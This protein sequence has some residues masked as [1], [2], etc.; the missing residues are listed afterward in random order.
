MIW[1][2]V[3]PSLQSESAFNYSKNVLH[4][5]ANF[6]VDGVEVECREVIYKHLVSPATTDVRGPLA[7]TLMGM[8]FQMLF[9]PRGVFG[10]AADATPLNEVGG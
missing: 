2:G 9:I 3:L 8:D 1:A 10:F 5:P 6:D 4:P 7:P